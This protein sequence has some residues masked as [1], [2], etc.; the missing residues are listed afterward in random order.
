MT[1][2]LSVYPALPLG[3]HARRPISSLPF[4]FGEPGS[5]VFA[6]SRHAMWH[7]ARALG[8]EPDAAILVPAY[9][10]GSEVEALR[11]A[12]L[13]LRF[14]DGGDRLEPLEDELDALVDDR[15]RALV[16]IHYLGFPQDA[17]RWRRWA[18]GR[19][20]LLIEDAAQSWLASLTEGPVGSFGDLAIYSLYKTYGLP[21][22]AA[23][24]GP[25]DAAPPRR[26]SPWGLVPTARKHAAWV[27][28]RW[29]APP[30]RNA[31]YDPAA[32]FDLGDPN[33]PPAAATR[34]LLP[35]LAGRR[36]AERRRRNFRRLASELAEFL[37]PPYEDLPEGASPFMFPI[38]AG[39]KDRVARRLRPTGVGVVDLW[40]VPH[41]LLETA[42]FPRAARLRAGVLGLPVHQE[43]RERDL[44][45]IARAVKA[46]AGP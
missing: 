23:V 12:G 44:E 43:L 24:L 29:V 40:S 31:P 26:R 1:A 3:V 37:P 14:Y 34:W 28:S 13:D 2:L 35:R 7:G 25:A 18:S 22:G 38:L 6:R 16:V 9:H 32:D 41:P 27:A 33:R 30:R 42:R 20:L 46:A 36:A 15:V 5:A 21:D 4:P 11:R 45:R 10:H 17:P 8:I 19:G 39:D